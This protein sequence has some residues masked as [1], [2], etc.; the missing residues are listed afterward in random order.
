MALTFF[1]PEQMSQA[2]KMFANSRRFIF[3]LSKI[4]IGNAIILVLVDDWI[5]KST[6]RKMA[7]P[8][9]LHS[10]LQ[11]PSPAYLLAHNP[12]KNINQSKY[13]TEIFSFP[14]F[15]KKIS[16]NILELKKINSGNSCGFQQDFL[17]SGLKG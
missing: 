2:K 4:S 10:D 11:H 17:R 13:S 9:P 1:K 5:K 7:S 14:F 8:S 6:S 15:G 3:N 12:Y 16:Q